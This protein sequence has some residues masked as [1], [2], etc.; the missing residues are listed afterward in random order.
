MKL[1]NSLAAIIAAAVL[2]L[3]ATAADATSNKGN[4]QG[5]A[6]GQIQGQAQ[7]QAQKSVNRN[8]NDNS[9][10]NR[11]RNVANG[12]AGGA[13]G[14]GGSANNEGNSQN[15]N[16]EEDGD[17]FPVSTAYA[18]ALA[19]SPD[20]CMGSSSAGAQGM[21]FGVSV[22]STWVD[23]NC[24]DLKW[25]REM[26]QAGYN[27]AAAAVLC[28]ARGGAYAQAMAAEGIDCAALL[29]ESS[30]GEQSAS[31]QAKP[32]AEERVEFDPILDRDDAFRHSRS[33]TRSDDGG[34]TL[35]LGAFLKKLFNA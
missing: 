14:A 5:Q 31:M 7:G 9:S 35:S 4:K 18:P 17:D 33:K 26:S 25:Y 24:M 28:Q 6:Q 16:I 1:G 20:T 32:I 34:E 15:V 19:A 21:S 10:T 8:N 30:E 11:N 3:S 23:K 27:K 2:A 29:G 22:G 12:G 13:G